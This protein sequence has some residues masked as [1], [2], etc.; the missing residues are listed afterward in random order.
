MAPSACRSSAAAGAQR[1]TSS[2]YLLGVFW[3]E[4]QHGCRAVEAL[5][6]SSSHPEQKPITSVMVLVLLWG[7]ELDPAT[8]WADNTTP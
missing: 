6:Q 2:M 8:S 7:T 4:G 1:S 5:T 3:H